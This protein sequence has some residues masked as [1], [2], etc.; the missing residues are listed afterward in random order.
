MELCV[1]GI[2]LTVVLWL[3][4]S[5]FFVME[6]AQGGDLVKMLKLTEP[7]ATFYAAEIALAL[8]FLHKR[9]I[10]HR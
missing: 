2:I 10:V 9:G 7:V 1:C 5:L 8:E 6:L 3:Q 4:E